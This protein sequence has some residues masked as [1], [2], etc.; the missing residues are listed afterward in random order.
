[1]IFWLKSRIFIH[2]SAGLC[3]ALVDRDR[4]LLISKFKIRGGWKARLKSTIKVTGKPWLEGGRTG[5]LPPTHLRTGLKFRPWKRWNAVF[6]RS[7]SCSFSF[8]LAFWLTSH[9]YFIRF[10]FELEAV[11]RLVGF[12]FLCSCTCGSGLHLQTDLLLMLCCLQYCNS[13]DTSVARSCSWCDSLRQCSCCFLCLA[14]SEL[15]ELFS[16]D[17]A[18]IFH[19]QPMR[20]TLFLWTVQKPPGSLTL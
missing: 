19:L 17:L 8:R 6:G 10:F 7:N 12:D 15:Y 2:A 1:M 4:Y 20:P 3:S 18:S 11:P 5:Q 13:C 9:P 14:R 16:R